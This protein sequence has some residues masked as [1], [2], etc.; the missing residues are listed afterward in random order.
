MVGSIHISNLNKIFTNRQK[1]TVTALSDVNIDIEPNSFIS[2]IGPSGCGKSTLLRLIA[3]LVEP[4]SGEISLDGRTIKGPGYERG[5]MF[6]E[7]NL[8]PWLTIYD[9]VAFGLRARKIYSERKNDVDEYIELVGLK[10]KNPIRISF[11]AACAREHHLH[12][13]LSVI[14]LFCCLMNRSGLWMLL[15]E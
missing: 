8:F 1:E 3:G 13:H 7:H 4:S 6:Q 5:F 15:P 2:L 11:P 14:L 12:V 10:G 9:N